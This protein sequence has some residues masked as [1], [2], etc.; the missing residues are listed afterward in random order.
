MKKLLA[1]VFAMLLTVSLLTGCGGSDNMSAAAD[2]PAAEAPAEDYIVMDEEIYVESESGLSSSDSTSNPL[3]ENQKIITTLYMDAETENMDP[4]L[5][6]INQKIQ[7]LGGYME[8]QDIYNGSSYNSYRYRYANMTIRIPAEKLD[9]FVNHVSEN[10]NIISK[11]TTTEN[12]TLTYIATESRMT[13]LETEQ[14]RLLELLAMAETME[15]LLLIESRLTEVRAELEQVGSVLRNYDNLINYSTIHLNIEEVKE[16]T[17]VEEPE[18]V[19]E[20]I[21]EGFVESLENVGNGLVDFFVFLIVALPYLLPFAA[22]AVIIIVIII[23]SNRKKKKKNDQQ[24][25]A[26]Q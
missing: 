9:S 17:E 1:L 24:P 6:D 10:A 12:V 4:L 14:T 2:A 16:Y 26:Q 3:P 25:P 18:T 13:A 20:R 22:V 19:W 23:A 8:A 15:D 5:T 21:S 11:N 7:E